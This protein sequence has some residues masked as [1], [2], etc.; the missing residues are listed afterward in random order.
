MRRGYFH[1]PRA[2]RGNLRPQ[3]CGR[4]ARLGAARDDA[5]ARDRVPR[6][7]RSPRWARS[8]TIAS[9]TRRSVGCSTASHRSRP[10]LPF[11]SDDASLIRVTRPRLGEGTAACPTGSASEMTR[12]SARRPPRLGRGEAKTDDFAS[13]LP[14]LRENVELK[15]RYI[16]CFEPA[17]LPLHRAAGRLRARDDD[18]RGSR[19]VRDPAACADRARPQ[20]ARGR[21][22]VPARILRSRGSS[23]ASQSG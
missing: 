14:Y 4:R 18:V 1:A 16:E 3:P 8:A 2:A 5:A 19:G 12:A 9:P 11:E 20:R 21:R 22:L 23:G 17:D 6:P 7:S 15:R 10:R 13:F